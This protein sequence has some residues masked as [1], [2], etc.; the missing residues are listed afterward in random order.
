G[1]VADGF[2]GPKSIAAVQAHLRAMMPKKNPWPGTS[3]EELTRFYGR[4]GDESKLIPMDVADLGMRYD[5]K[6][7]RVLRCHRAVAA[8]LLRVL[9]GIA[10]GPCRSVLERYA[11]CYNNRPMRGGSLPSLHARGAAVDLDP[12]SN[13]NHTPWPSRATMPLEVMEQFACEGWTCAG[14]FWLRDPM[15]FQATA[16]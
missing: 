10:A 13:G 8:S 4:A 6:P 2:F 9:Q 15:H 16:L 12:D 7:V 5:G 1:V 3:Q 14:A 11:G